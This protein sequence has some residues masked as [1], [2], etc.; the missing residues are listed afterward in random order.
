MGGM[1]GKKGERSEQQK[2]RAENHYENELNL[3]RFDVE[4]M[5]VFIEDSSRLYSELCF[6]CRRGANFQRNHEKK[7]LESEKWS[8]RN[9]GYIK[10]LPKWLMVK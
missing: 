3:D 9:V 1:E 6:L 4:K 8:Q 10:I 5:R 2:D 7:L